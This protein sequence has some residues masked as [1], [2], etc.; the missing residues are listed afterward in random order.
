MLCVA[1]GLIWLGCILSVVKFVAWLSES[2]SRERAFYVLVTA[3]GVTGCA[4]L[5]P[6]EERFSNPFFSGAADLH[7]VQWIATVKG[8]F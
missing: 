1:Y 8:G 4:S 2:E 6:Y 5:S 3:A 7:H